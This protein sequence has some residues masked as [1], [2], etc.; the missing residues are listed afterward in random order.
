MLLQDVFSDNAIRNLG[1]IKLMSLP[2]NWIEDRRIAGIRANSFLTWYHPPDNPDVTIG[3]FFRG[4]RAG[5][6]TSRNFR[7]LLS[8]PPHTLTA[9]E[10]QTLSEVLDDSADPNEFTMQSGTTEWLNRRHVLVVQGIYIRAQQCSR[11]IYINADGT[12]SAIQE[13]YYAAPVE[14]F[15]VYLRESLEAFN[16]IRWI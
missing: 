1:Q 3:F 8:L 5:R 11:T 6:L 15:P 12:G 7:E 13:I 2:D 16:S 9:A 4:K 10:L 14:Q